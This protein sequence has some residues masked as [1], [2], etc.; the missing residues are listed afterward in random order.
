MLTSGDLDTR[1][2]P[3]QARKMT[4]ALQ[5][6]TASGL[7]VIL[8]YDAQA[9]HAAGRRLPRGKMIENTA[10]ELTFLLSRLGAGGP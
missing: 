7:P 3:L 5:R 4:A 8:R 1:V 6:V 9:G 2:P 10:G